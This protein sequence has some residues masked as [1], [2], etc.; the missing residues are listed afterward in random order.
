MQDPRAFPGGHDLTGLPDTLML[1]A[2]RDSLRASGGAFAEELRRAGVPLRY[3][4]V[5]ETPHGFLNR[6]GTPGYDAGV[7]IMTDWLGGR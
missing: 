3:E 1:D 5:P 6:P 2:D 7:R 4:V